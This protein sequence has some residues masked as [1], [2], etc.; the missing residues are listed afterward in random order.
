MAKYRIKR[1]LDLKARVLEP[2]V[3]NGKA[4]AAFAAIGHP[5]GFFDIL[6]REGFNL[7]REFVYP[8]HHQLTSFEFDSIQNELIDED[9]K[10]LLITHK[11]KY[12]LPKGVG[13]QVKVVIVDVDIEIE[14]AQE[15]LQNIL[16]KLK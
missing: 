11:D 16:S 5:K 7:K 14:K 9:I 13:P 4:V 3:L 15:L 12:H 6:K 1:F 8:D 2:D 10:Y